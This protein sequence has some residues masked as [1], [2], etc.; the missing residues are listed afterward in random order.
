M[1]GDTSLSEQ[2]FSVRAHRLSYPKISLTDDSTLWIASLAEPRSKYPTEGGSHD[3]L[4]LARL[5]T[6]LWTLGT[7]RLAPFNAPPHNK[8]ENFIPE[9]L[10]PSDSNLF[11]IS[12]GRYANAFPI[13]RQPDPYPRILDPRLP[14]PPLATFMGNPIYRSN[15]RTVA[16]A[17]NLNRSLRITLASPSL[18]ILHDTIIDGHANGATLEL[19]NYFYSRKDNGIELLYSQQLPRNTSGIRYFLIDRQAGMEDRD[20]VVDV[21]YHFLLY[22]SK[23]ISPST[24]VVPFTYKGKM[25]F[26]MLFPRMN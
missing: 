25:G 9:Y 7:P 8:D 12:T 10:L 5:D 20:L 6:S 23:R 24:L 26:Q 21:H 19:D 17:K 3:L 14:E 18:N 15:L 2:K 16:Q 1:I 4:F 13:Y 11:I 22:L